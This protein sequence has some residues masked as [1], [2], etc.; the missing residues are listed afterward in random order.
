MISWAGV[1]RDS[2]WQVDCSGQHIRHI[3][4][5][6]SETSQYPWTRF[7]FGKFRFHLGRRRASSSIATTKAFFEVFSSSTPGAARSG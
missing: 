7:S 2:E 1:L 5:A 6:P 3:E 4:I